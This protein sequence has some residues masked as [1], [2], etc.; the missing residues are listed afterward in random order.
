[1]IREKQRGEGMALGLNN[2]LLPVTCGIKPSESY[3]GYILRLSG[4]NG[5]A[6][7]SQMLARINKKSRPSPSTWTEPGVLAS[8]TGRPLQEFAKSAYRVRQKDGTNMNLGG[9][10]VTSRMI[11]TLNLRICPMCVKAKGIIESHFDLQLMVICPEHGCELVDTC[12]QCGHKLSW[13]RPDLLVCQCGADLASVVGHSPDAATRE[14]LEIVRRKVHG[15]RLGSVSENGFPLKEIDQISL[16]SLLYLAD[17][18]GRRVVGGKADVSHQEYS[19]IVSK[20]SAVLSNWPHNAMDWFEEIAP[21]A[22]DAKVFKL[23]QQSLRGIYLCLLHGMRP[24]EDGNFV[25]HALSMF[26]VRNNGYGSHSAFG[27][28][29]EA[30]NAVGYTNMKGFSELVGIDPRNVGR[31]VQQNG[32]AVSEMPYGKQKRLRIEQSSALQFMGDGKK[33][34]SMPEASTKLGIVIPVLRELKRQGVYEAKRRLDAKGFHEADLNS[35]TRRV[36]TAASQPSRKGTTR[37]TL[38]S[39]QSVFKSS[40]VC[41]T[42]K[43]KIISGI[44][45]GE[46]VGITK[47]DETIGGILIPSDSFVKVVKTKWKIRKPNDETR[48]TWNC[49]EVAAR[50][51]IHSLA[52]LGLIRDGHLEADRRGHA[53]LIS[54]ESVAQFLM[55]YRSIASVAKSMGVPSAVVTRVCELGGYVYIS[56]EKR[57]SN[58]RGGFVLAADVERLRE[59]VLANNRGSSRSSRRVKRGC[60]ARVA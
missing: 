20:A 2:A 9:H 7:P 12:P 19:M 24:K 4:R 29:I 18:L 54:K 30:A 43:V 10:E 39:L 8:L 57:G 58:F 60:I 3:L 46:M 15:I 25:R 41:V 33:I 37:A 47:T 34:Y 52:I 22:R 40:R 55:K 28:G 31:V 21:D 13:K 16:R 11:R 23:T 1:M 35:F 53:W 6:S 27:G 48:S 17:T 32:V 45:S 38:V 14:F 56:T 51:G 50:T 44:L 49:V 59:A 26:A 5:Y 42:E 36:L